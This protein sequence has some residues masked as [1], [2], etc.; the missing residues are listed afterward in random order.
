[1]TEAAR[2]C[3]KC[4]REHEAGSKFCPYCGAGFATDDMHYQ[5]DGRTVSREDDT[6]YL[7]SPPPKYKKSRKGVALAL[8]L[9]AVVV[10]LMVM[11]PSGQTPT[12]YDEDTIHRSEL[13]L[14]GQYVL[15]NYHLDKHTYSISGVEYLSYTLNMTIKNEKVQNLRPDEIRFFIVVDGNSYD[16]RRVAAYGDPT[17]IGMGATF[18]T[19][20]HISP[21]P[22]DFKDK[23]I[24]LYHYEDRFK[25]YRDPE[26]SIDQN[27]LI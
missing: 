9:L 16:L 5:N 2:I 10:A 11:V 14:D 18:T 3:W 24:A 13:P 23:E 7:S 1:M 8:V 22:V 17:Y 15:T 6:A 4:H 19:T 21:L 25:I 12:G 26:V 27:G 20:Y